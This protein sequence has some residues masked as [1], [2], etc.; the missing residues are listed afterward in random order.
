[1][2]NRLKL[3]VAVI[4]GILLLFYARVTGVVYA[5]ARCTPRAEKNIF[6]PNL[7]GK[8]V[9]APPGRARVQFV[10]KLGDLDGGSR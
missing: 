5:H 4:E 6:G 2:L 1:M 7:Q 9:S 8:L 10:K 3:D